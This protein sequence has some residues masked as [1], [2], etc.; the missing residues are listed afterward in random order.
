MIA[1]YSLTGTLLSSFATGTDFMA[2]L[3][4]DPADGTLWFTYAGTN[5][6]FQYSTSGTF[7]QSGEP[8]GLP[9]GFY[10]AG[11]FAEPEPEPATL[12]LSPA[13]SLVSA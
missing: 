13:V 1:D 12:L 8:N 5:E 3:A 2:E 4:F 9:G 10:F 6:L 7:L 11:E